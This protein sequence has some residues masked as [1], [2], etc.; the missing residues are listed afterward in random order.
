MSLT[1]LLYG[2]V[3]EHSLSFDFFTEMI[4]QETRL[5]MRLMKMFGAFERSMSMGKQ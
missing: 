3:H 5:K 1:L 4:I 2:Q